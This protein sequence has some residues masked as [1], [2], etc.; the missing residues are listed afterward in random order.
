MVNGMFV[1]FLCTE[2]AVWAGYASPFALLVHCL[3]SR[4]RKAIQF[5]RVG[6]ARCD[7]GNRLCGTWRGF[8]LASG[9][10]DVFKKVKRSVCP[11]SDMQ[12]CVKSFVS[13]RQSKGGS[14]RCRGGAVVASPVIF[15]WISASG[16]SCGAGTTRGR[17]SER[18]R[19]VGEEALGRSSASSSS[20]ETS[21]PILSLRV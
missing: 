21:Y 18:G 1:W 7:S 20:R 14:V 6:L 15:W 9:R 13:A 8:R 5:E 16:G 3:E 4:R 19:A 11:G 2:W 10:G 12:K 17:C